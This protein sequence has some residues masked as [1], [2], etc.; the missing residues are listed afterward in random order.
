MARP[1]IPFVVGNVKTRLLCTDEFC[2]QIMEILITVYIESYID[3]GKRNTRRT[4]A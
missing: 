2:S 3:E 4:W 1:V